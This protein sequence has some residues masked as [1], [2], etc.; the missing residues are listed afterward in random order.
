MPKGQIPKT[1]RAEWQQ[2]ARRGENYPRCMARLQKRADT[3]AEIA[4]NAAEIEKLKSKISKN[5]SVLA[6]DWT[7]FWY[8][9]LKYKEE[10][11]AKKRLAQAAEAASSRS[12]KQPL[13]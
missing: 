1:V 11:I 12:E 5:N 9:G 8:S 6:I 3:Q 4:E 10:R 13:F 2:Y 7:P